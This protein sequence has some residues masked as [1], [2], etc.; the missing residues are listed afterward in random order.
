MLQAVARPGS[1]AEAHSILASS[2]SA[3]ILAGGTVVMP[4]ADQQAILA[5]TATRVYRL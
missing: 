1:L 3:A 2:K 5:G 4:L